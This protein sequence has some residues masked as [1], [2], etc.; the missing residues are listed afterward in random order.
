MNDEF[1]FLYYILNYHF[2]SERL[3]VQ[4]S[5]V[6][7]TTVAFFADMF[8]SISESEATP[9][10]ILNFDIV[11]TNADNGYHSSTG[12]SFYPNLESTCF[13]GVSGT[14]STIRIP[15]N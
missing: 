4:P 7:P 8:S 5:L 14:V 6:T 11:K 1:Y 12:I 10:N 9:N 2:H 15:P 13:L 3:L